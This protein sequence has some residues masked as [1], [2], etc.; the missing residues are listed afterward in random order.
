M[1]RILRHEKMGT[2]DLGWLRSIFH[3]SF[4]EYHNPDNMNFGALRVINDD[5]IEPGTGFPTHPHSNM[6]IITYVIDGAL[7]HEDS[8]GNKREI[9][10]GEVQYMSAGT[11]LTH[12]EYNLG[13]ELLRLLQIWIIPDKKG[14]S[15]NYGDLAP[16]W[17]SRVGKWLNIVS[18][19]QGRG[20]T[21]IQQDASISVTFLDKG[22]TLEYEIGK[23]RQIYLVQIEGESRLNGNIM[24]ERD[25]A[26]IYDTTEK[27]AL[28]ARTDSHYLIV[29]LSAK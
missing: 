18:G 1:I 10:R 9:K 26:E 4:A 22:K 28:T 13:E 27:I 16:I 19:E 17:D 7:T 3:F 8:M 12:S 25:G 20:L 6:E 23:D 5:L 15:T 24:R 11:G 21:K 29:D 2:S 14:H